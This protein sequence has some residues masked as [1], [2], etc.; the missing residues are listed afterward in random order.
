MTTYTLSTAEK[1]NVLQTTIWT[2]DEIEISHSQLFRWGSWSC[3]DK[4][5]LDIDTSNPYGY[6]VYDTDI[7][8][9][10]ISMDDCCWENWNWGALEADLQLQIEE[11]FNSD[12]YSWLDEN[13]W[14]EKESIVI[15]KGPLLIDSQL[16]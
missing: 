14:I 9:E 4:R 13:G 3:H 11:G 10:L 7:E 12:G 1:K 15:L 8:W 2:K 16:G 6:S 5:A